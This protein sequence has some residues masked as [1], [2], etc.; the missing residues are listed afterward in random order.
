MFFKN[1]NLY[2]YLIS[3]MFDFYV[4]YNIKF[5]FLFVLLNNIKFNFIK[6][7]LLDYNQIIKK[8]NNLNN[9]K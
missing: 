6:R 4:F 3:F 1:I 9:Y 2:F 5:D 7:Y 8:I